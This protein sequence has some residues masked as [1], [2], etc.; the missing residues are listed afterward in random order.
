MNTGATRRYGTE[1]RRAR[2]HVSG[3]R[4]RPA[5]ASA[6][7]PNAVGACPLS[8]LLVEVADDVR[9]GRD[10]RLLHRLLPGQDLAQHRAE[11]IAALD[12]GPVLRRRDEPARLRSLIVEAV[13]EQVR[14]VRNVALRL[15]R[16]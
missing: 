7:A 11:D 10:G 15:Q 14:R 6:A 4:G 9:V 16:L 8:A 13:V 5:A 12:V 1:P 3:R 2:L